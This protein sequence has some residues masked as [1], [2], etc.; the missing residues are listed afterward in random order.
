MA[1]SSIAAAFLIALAAAPAFAEPLTAE[2]AIARQKE[3]LRDALGLDCDR[4]GQGEDI[5]VCGRSGPDPNRVPFPDQ[6]LPGERVRLGPSEAPSG[7]AGLEAGQSPCSTVGP[8]QRC[9]GGLDV[10]RVVGVLAKIAK[11]LIDPEE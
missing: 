2:E 4:S 7:L 1:K 5:V 10:F 3:Q 9:S 6:R 8:N 11:H